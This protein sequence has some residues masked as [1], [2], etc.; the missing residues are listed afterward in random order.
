MRICT[1]A[2]HMRIYTAALMPNR[3]R[4]ACTR[5]PNIYAAPLGL[6]WHLLG[7]P[8][9]VSTKLHMLCWLQAST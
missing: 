8:E 7:H 2:H 3:S 4:S 6:L 5:V 1:A 9:G